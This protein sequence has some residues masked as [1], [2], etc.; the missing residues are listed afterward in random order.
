VQDA[1]M[2]LAENY[3]ARPAAELPLLF[4]RILQNVIYDFFR[5]QKV[6][7]TWVTLFS[8]LGSREDGEDVDPL[9]TLEA[10]YGSEAAESAA[11]KFER[12]QVVGNYRGRDLALAGPSTGGLSDA[13][14]G[15]Y[16][17]GGNRSGNGLF[18]GKRQDA[19]FARHSRLGT[20]PESARHPAMNDQEFGYR[21]RQALDEGADRLDYTTVYRLEAARQAALASHRPRKPA[22]SVSEFGR[23]GWMRTLGTGRARRDADHRLHRDLRVAAPEADH[24][25]G[26]HGL[27]SIAGQHAD[28]RLRG[29]EL[30]CPASRQRR[31]LSRA[32]MNAHAALVALI[33]VA[34]AFLTSPLPAQSQVQSALSSEST[35]SQGA[36]RLLPALHGRN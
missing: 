21:I 24:R 19:L 9:E 32:P 29:Q 1:M 14:L 5:R 18:G 16:G 31:T 33:A 20:G 2:K 30:H 22:H 3:G 35:R 23:G 27:R 25:S 6:R 15:G 4:T 28:R 10:L 17:R 34:D 8:A 12:S 13:L 7:S 26:Q 36:C 11:D